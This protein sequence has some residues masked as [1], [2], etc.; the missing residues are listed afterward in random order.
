MGPVDWEH[1]SA[2]DKPQ[3]WREAEKNVS[4]FLFN[5]R[6]LLAMRMY[7]GW[8]YWKPTPAVYFVGPLNS[9]EWAHFN[10]YGAHGNSITRK[11][12]GATP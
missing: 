6:Q 11:P 12:E 7:D 2:K 10:S 9:G 3:I 5:G 1:P 8:P 4:S